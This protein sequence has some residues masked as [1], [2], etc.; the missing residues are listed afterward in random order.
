MSGDIGGST[1]V[2]VLR[3]RWRRRAGKIWQQMEKKSRRIKLK[4]VCE[5]QELQPT[6]KATPGLSKFKI[7][8]DGKLIN[9]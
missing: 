4:K 3:M 2:F 1:E 7:I 8:T 9:A 6:R 5:R